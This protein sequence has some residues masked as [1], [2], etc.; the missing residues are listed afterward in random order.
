MEARLRSGLAFRKTVEALT[1]LIVAHQL[2]EPASKFAMTPGGE[3]QTRPSVVDQFGDP[4]DPAGDDGQ[5]A[6][7]CFK[8]H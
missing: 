6:S 8:V 7:L 3:Q 1:E 2:A 4:A 5:A